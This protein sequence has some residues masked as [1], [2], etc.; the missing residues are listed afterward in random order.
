MISF[1]V[2]LLLIFDR[3]LHLDVQKRLTEKTLKV[4]ETNQVIESIDARS[5]CFSNGSFI[6]YKTLYL[7]NLREEC[8]N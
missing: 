8:E 6:R 1:E 4:S 5:P 3:L 2:N 7:S